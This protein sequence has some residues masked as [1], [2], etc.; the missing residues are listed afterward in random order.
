MIGIN[1]V[2][3]EAKMFQS[4]NKRTMTYPKYPFTCSSSIYTVIEFKK[5]VTRNLGLER[6][7]YKHTSYLYHRTSHDVMFIQCS[8]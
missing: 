7:I 2:T 4:N 8:D 5:V 1:W 6:I 3:I